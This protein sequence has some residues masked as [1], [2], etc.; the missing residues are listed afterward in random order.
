MVE[1]WLFHDQE[2]EQVK[3]SDHFGEE[4]FNALLHVQEAHPDAIPQE[5]DVIDDY[6]LAR[7]EGGEPNPRLLTLEYPRK[8]LIGSIDGIP[9]VKNS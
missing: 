1:G 5:V 4:F 9:A 7:Q 6:G 8:I 3:M 2:G